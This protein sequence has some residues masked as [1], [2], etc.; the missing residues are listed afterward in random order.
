QGS[1]K[2]NLDKRERLTHLLGAMRAFNE[3]LNLRKSD[4]AGEQKKWEV[5]EAVLKLC[6][7]SQSY[8][9]AEY[10]L[11]E[12][13]NLKS[14]D[15]GKK[16]ELQQNLSVEKNRVQ[17]KHLTRF[18][19]WMNKLK[20]GRVFEGEQED[21]LYEIVKMS[22]KEI[23]HQL[24][25]ELK[26]GN[27]YFLKLNSESV[28]AKKALLY[29]T[30]VKILG[31]LEPKEAIVEL[32]EGLNQLMQQVSKIP[33]G[34][35][36]LELIN[37]MVL[38]TQAL[39]NLGS[40]G[41]IA[42]LENLRFK[43]GGDS[44]FWTRTQQ[45]YRKLLKKNPQSA[46]D[47]KESNETFFYFFYKRGQQ[48][49]ELR[50]YEGA[51]QDYTEAIHLNPRFVLAYNNRGIAKFEKGD[52]DGAIQDY[53]QAIRIN[54][55]FVL[56]YNN[57]GFTKQA[58]G[59]FNGAIQDCTEALR[60]NPQFYSA[61]NNR[62]NAKRDKG[63]FNGAIQDYNLALQLNSHDSDAY[64]NR[65]FA[66]LAKEDFDGVIQDCTE[67]LRINPQFANAYNN[68]GSA[69]E[70]KGDLD[71]AIQDC[72]EA[73]RINPQFLDA[74]YNRGNAKFEKL[75]FDGAIQDYTEALRLNPQFVIASHYRG[76]AKYTKGDFDGAIQ[77][78]TEALRLNP[79]YDDVYHYRGLAKSKKG[80]RNG[81]KEDFSIFLE[82]TQ[83]TL[84]PQTLQK[85]Q[86]IFKQFP[87]LKEKQ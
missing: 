46:E 25:E 63:D 72:T 41:E 2:S 70:A 32:R 77:D 37:Y 61:Y 57:R 24:L 31:R 34:K 85:R 87:E 7:E 86:S 83:N 15:A 5:G 45:A 66:K 26:A 21:I 48:K 10:I 35:R 67:A 14:I 62:G 8:Q 40:R 30:V 50:D 71:G 76:L 29:G 60:I 3:A 20:E 19:Y 82:R 54:P 68:R 53:T 9:L 4:P 44:L 80:D 64:Y 51:I 1:E 49:Y 52:V 42:F 47:T 65:G 17:E 79:Q 84:V 59:D 23:Y 11:Q 69:K 18:E 27:E 43:M 78:Y 56:A 16:A 6:Y 81:A 75:D 39:G 58:K 55:Q 73:L 33:E 36:S 74:Y 12:V 22:E 13:A 28:E 38:R